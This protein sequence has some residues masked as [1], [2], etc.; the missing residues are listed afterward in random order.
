MKVVNDEYTVTTQK[1]LDKLFA[2]FKCESHKELE[3]RFWCTY[4]VSLNIDIK[5]GK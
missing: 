2:E 3:M 5:D 4:G 1:E